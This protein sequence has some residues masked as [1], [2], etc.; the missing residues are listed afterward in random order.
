[1]TIVMSIPITTMTMMTMIRV[2]TVTIMMMSTRWNN[3][4]DYG[5]GNTS[6]N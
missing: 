5:D 2:T 3:D 1:M 4:Y 6:L